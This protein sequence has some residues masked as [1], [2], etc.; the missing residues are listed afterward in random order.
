MIENMAE[1]VVLPVAE[2]LVGVGGLRKA[3]GKANT[4][5]WS[6]TLRAC[7]KIT[8]CCTR[9]SRLPWAQSGF[10]SSL[11]ELSEEPNGSQRNLGRNWPLQDCCL[12][13]GAKCFKAMAGWARQQ[14]V[15]WYKAWCNEMWFFNGITDIQGQYFCIIEHMCLLT[16]LY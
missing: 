4:K 10:S 1:V 9:V 3:F 7:C 13:T 14:A 8:D 16:L 5:L 6:V 2:M 11:M 15:N 12:F